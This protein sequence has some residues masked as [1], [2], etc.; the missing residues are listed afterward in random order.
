MARQG[1][2][3]T[4]I[5][6]YMPTRARGN[7]A[8]GG[9]GMAG[10]VARM[11]RA[12]RCG[13]GLRGGGSAAYGEGRLSACACQV[14][15]ANEPWLCWGSSRSIHASLVALA[16]QLQ[17]I[18]KINELLKPKSCTRMP[19]LPRGRTHAF[20]AAFHCVAGMPAHQFITL[21][22][23]SKNLPGFAHWLVL[24]WLHCK[25]ITR[26]NNYAMVT[27]EPPYKNK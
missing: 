2:K 14:C 27:K 19:S 17:K 3:Q 10:W 7:S 8:A 21:L 1:A 22:T 5:K 12:T 11:R 6:H 9:P 23:L 13:V 20:A 24:T 16:Y 18:S 4:S 25:R 15:G 26:G